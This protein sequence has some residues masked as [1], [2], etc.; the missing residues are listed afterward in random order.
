MIDDKKKFPPIFWIAFAILV[1]INLSVFFD[2]SKPIEKYQRFAGV[3]HNIEL[4]PASVLKE[5]VRDGQKLPECTVATGGMLTWQ[6]F[7]SGVARYQFNPMQAVTSDTSVK[8]AQNAVC[9]AGDI[10]DVSS[11][12]DDNHNT[13]LILLSIDFANPLKQ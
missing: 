10:V 4:K 2:Y 7:A 13:Q 1:V 9:L 3:T 6:S 12:S 8:S 5:I 11:L